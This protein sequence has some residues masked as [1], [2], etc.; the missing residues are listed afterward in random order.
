MVRKHRVL[1]GVVITGCIAAL[2]LTV[3]ARASHDDRR[4]AGKS[5]SP[6][7]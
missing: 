7:R 5:P 3:V 6:S 4:P 2:G 1:F